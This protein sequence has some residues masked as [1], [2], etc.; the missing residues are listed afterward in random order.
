M[1]V[2]ALIIFFGILVL[3]L[4]LLSMVMYYLKQF[5]VG[6]MLLLVSY[7]LGIIPFYEYMEAHM[8][9]TSVSIVVLFWIVIVSVSIGDSSEV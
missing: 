3:P 5:S 7:G 8:V 6:G 9:L 1:E 2:V 4:L